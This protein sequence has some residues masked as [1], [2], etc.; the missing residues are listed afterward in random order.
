[1]AT[2][3]QMANPFDVE[4]EE[5]ISLASGEVL[6]TTAA[7]RL[8]SAEQLG[9]EQFLKFM[10]DNLFCEEPN[11]FAKL[12]RNK[13]HTF[14]SGKKNA[15]K[16]CKGKETSIKLNIKFFARLLVI[17]KNR[18]ID[19]K[20]VL[21]YS[22]GSFPLSIATPTGGLVKTAKSKLLEIVESEAGNPEVDIHSYQNNALIVDTMAIL[23]IIKGK[24]YYTKRGFV[25]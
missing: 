1:V 5:L 8:L 19:L 7:D 12:E 24:L 14:T 25:A 22:L 21:S 17:S 3:A 15:V 20:E 9:E 18:E 2:V 16:D 11:I 10:E 6:E 23:Q 13:L 4:Q